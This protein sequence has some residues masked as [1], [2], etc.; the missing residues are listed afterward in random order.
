MKKGRSMQQ[1]VVPSPALKWP[2]CYLLLTV[3]EEAFEVIPSGKSWLPVIWKF[4]HLRNLLF[5]FFLS[6]SL[7]GFVLSFKDEAKVACGLGG[8]GSSK[9]SFVCNGEIIF[10]SLYNQNIL[11]L[12]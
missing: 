10:M 11:N 4:C 6:L 2:L 1:L 8:A 3:L 5:F 9:L 12:H 7:F